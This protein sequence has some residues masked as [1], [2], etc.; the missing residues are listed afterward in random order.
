MVATKSDPNCVEPACADKMVFF[1]SSVGKKARKVAAQSKEAPTDCPLDRKE[2]GNATWGLVRWLSG[3]N[4]GLYGL[5]CNRTACNVSVAALN[6]HLLPG[7]AVAGVPG[8]GQ[9]VHRS[10]GAHVP[11]RALRR[12]FPE[13]DRQVSATVS[14]LEVVVQ[15]AGVTDRVGALVFVLVLQ[16]GVAHDLLHVAV[17]AAQHCEP[18]DPQAC[19]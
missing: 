11:V 6:G 18:Q 17:R 19:V 12:R 2:L 4:D 10:A 15:L 13:G 5:S 7:Q 3:E 16:C 9:D 14:C 8:Q 1:K